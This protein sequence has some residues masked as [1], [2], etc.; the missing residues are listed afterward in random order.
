VAGWNAQALS[1]AGLTSQLSLVQENEADAAAAMPFSRSMRKKCQHQMWHLFFF[2]FI[3]SLHARSAGSVALKPL[4]L[5]SCLLSGL[6]VIWF[7]LFLVSMT[8]VIQNPV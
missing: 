1:S 2:I 7:I 6:L 4:D 5:Q 8:G 3:F